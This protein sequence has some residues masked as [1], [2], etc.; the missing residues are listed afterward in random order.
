MAACRLPTDLPRREL[1]GACM[2]TRQPAPAPSRTARPRLI[3]APPL[4]SCQAPRRPATHVQS[5]G[6]PAHLASSQL[7]PTPMSTAMRRVVVPDPDHLALD[8]LARDGDLV[9]GAFEEQLVVD[10]EDQA[11]LQLGDVERAVAA[12]H[13]ELDDVGGGALD[14]GVD[15]EAFAEGAHLVVAGAQLGDLAAPAPER[16]D[17]ALLL[18]LVDGVDH[19]VALRAGSGRGRRR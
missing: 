9:G 2:P 15:G 8:Q 1:T 5:A 16:L 13:R 18:G 14:D 3:A 7:A 6:P 11:G 12:D 17:V 10:G 4:V 19:E